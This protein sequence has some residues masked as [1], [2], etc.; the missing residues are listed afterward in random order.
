MDDIDYGTNSEF[1]F[2]R[3]LGKNPFSRYPRTILLNR[4]LESCEKR[5]N[6]DR[7]DKRLVVSFAYSQLNEEH[8]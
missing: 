2:I 7:I 1:R 4:Y 6:W 3:S 5:D 8:A